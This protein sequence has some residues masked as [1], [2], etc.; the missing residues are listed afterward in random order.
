MKGSNEGKEKGHN[1]QAAR[2]CEPNMPPCSSLFIPPNNRR[3][4]LF[5]RIDKG[6]ACFL[7]AASSSHGVDKA[8]CNLHAGVFYSSPHI[9]ARI[10]VILGIPR[11]GILAVL[12]AKTVISVSQNSSG[13]WN[14]H[15]ITR[16]ES[17]GMESMEFFFN[18][19]SKF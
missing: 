7:H 10:Q 9:P 2:Q 16:T 12:P 18:S 15:R 19:N 17:T 14:G 13:F 5:C 1:K 11:N 3:R 8:V 6:A 4:L